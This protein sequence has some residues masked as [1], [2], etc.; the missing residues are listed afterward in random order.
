MKITNKRTKNAEQQTSNDIGWIYELCNTPLWIAARI[1][2]DDSHPLKNLESSIKKGDAYIVL[3]NEITPQTY[4]T[5]PHNGARGYSV[6][7]SLEKGLDYANNSKSY[8][9]VAVGQTTLESL[10][11]NIK[12]NEYGITRV[13]VDMRLELDEAMV[14]LAEKIIVENGI[15]V[16]LNDDEMAAAGASQNDMITKAA[17]FVRSFDTSKLDKLTDK[18]AKLFAKLKADVLKGEVFPAVRKDELHFYYK[19]GCLYRFANGSFKRNP[20]YDNIETV[21]I[22]DYKK[23][24][25]Q[26]RIRYSGKDDGAKERQLLDNLNHHTFKKGSTSR[27]IVLD[28]EVNLNGGKSGQKKC[29][30]VLLNKDTNEIM[31]VEGKVFKDSRVNRRVGETPEVIEQVATYTAGINEQATAIV[32]QY[33]KHIRVVNALFGTEYNTEGKLILTAKLLVYETPKA[34]NANGQHSIDTINSALGI[35]NI[36]WVTADNEPTLDEIW[37][38]LCK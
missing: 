20:A 12:S 17:G 14:A 34:P 30:M 16:K 15:V 19:G 29:D 3:K 6:F 22:D 32:E 38:V 11:K 37:D 9:V 35:K 18:D 28:I 1:V 36:L 23:A 2:L 27:I 8:G 5:N 7:T 4:L 33:A 25:E 24:K 10:I 21:E 13:I 31:F 26:C